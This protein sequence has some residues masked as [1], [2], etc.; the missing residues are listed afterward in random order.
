MSYELKIERKPGYL[1][2]IVT[3]LNTKGN[4]KAYLEEI[5]KA[6]I[7]SHCGRVLIEERLEGPRLSTMDV[8]SIASEGGSRFAGRLQ[9]IAYV[10]VNQQGDLMQFAENVAFNRGLPL[11]VFPTVA[12]AE[13]WLLDRARQDSR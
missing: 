2:A 1:H 6:C 11:V 7:E 5:M 13:A 10:D 12:E 8:F 3:G 9:A 4:V